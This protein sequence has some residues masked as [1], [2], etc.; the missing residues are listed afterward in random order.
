M[1]V[2]IISHNAISTTNNMGKTM[3][4][5]FSE[6]DKNEICQL[7]IHPSMPDVDVCSSYYH[8]TDEEI[9]ESVFKFN[10]PGQ[11][12][13][14]SEIFCNKEKSLRLKNEIS[15]YARKNSSDPIKRLIRDFVWKISKWDN[16][17]LDSWLNKEKPT[18]IFLAPGYAKFIYDIALS[19][20]KK[21]NIPIITYICDDYYFVKEPGKPISKLQ[22]RLLRNKTD[23]VMQNTQHL[24]AIS[25][26]IKELYSKK[27]DVNA[28]V[29]MTGSELSFSDDL[30]YSNRPKSI[31]YFGNIGLNRYISLAEIG[32]ML[33][34]INQENNTRYIL[35]IYTD[36]IGNENIK[37]FEDIKSIE[38]RDFL[39]G[40]KFKKEFLASDILLHV[41]AFDKESID[42]VR[43]SISTKIADSLASGIPM[44]AY[45]PSEVASIKYLEKSEAATI[46]TKK[47]LLKNRLYQI[48]NNEVNRKD[49]IENALR[50][51]KKNHDIKA[52]SLKLYN[53]IEGIH[54]K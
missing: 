7:F 47:E 14:K 15:N 18:C 46:C 40:E 51:A 44:F 41:E 4:S 10:I 26:G 45:G 38:L 22:L 9:L 23:V 13:D 54:C 30:K 16:A 19:I 43:Y 53:I 34:K 48:F 52:V 12:L 2:L 5:L 49:T 37:H 31:S 20:S 1:K 21:L 25:D 3:Y 6:F 29:I 35:K 27:F 32:K 24:I 42:I 50:L 36:N 33:D 28:T 17:K 11:E 8:I 39:S